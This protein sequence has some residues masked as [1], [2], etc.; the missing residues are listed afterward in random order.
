MAIDTHRGHQMKLVLG[1]WRYADNGITVELDKNRQ[2]GHCQLDNT[3]EGHD[4]CLGV[5]PKVMNACCGHGDAKDAYVQF[6]DG[7]NVHG[8]N[9]IATIE[10]LK[11]K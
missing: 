10:I 4:G 7:S 6:N 8:I 3:P 9:A 1:R 5:L 2:C 11:G